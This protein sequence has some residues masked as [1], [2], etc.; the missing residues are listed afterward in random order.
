MQINEDGRGRVSRPSSMAGGSVEPPRTH[1]LTVAG[2]LVVCFSV[3][4]LAMGARGEGFGVA[5][6]GLVAAATGVVMIVLGRV[7]ALRAPR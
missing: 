3:V 4:P 7:L 5:E 2:W 1:G 6:A